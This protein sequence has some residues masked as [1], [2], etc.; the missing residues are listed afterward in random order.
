MQKPLKDFAQSLK[1]V[2]Q[3][4]PANYPISPIFKSIADEETIRS[5]VLAFKDF[6]CQFFDYVIAVASLHD[7][8]KL[9]ANRVWGG[10]NFTMDYPFLRDMAMTL[11]N[12]G[13]HGEPNNNNDALIIN[14]SEL[15]SVSKKTR[16]SKVTVYLR[17]LSEC[18]IEIFGIDLDTEKPNLTYTNILEITYPD[19]PVMLIGLKAMA[20]AQLE[21]NKKRF[22]PGAA[23]CITLMDTIFL[24]CDH[25]ALCGEVAE[26]ISLIKDIS[27]PFPVG[28]RELVLSLH[29]RLIDAGFICDTFTGRNSSIGTYFL[30]NYKRKPKSVS[31]ASWIIGITPNSCG[32][33]IDAKNASEY[34]EVIEKFPQ[35]L[36][37]VIK[38]GS[39]CIHTPTIHPLNNTGYKFIIDGAEYLKCSVFVCSNNNF[40]VPLTDL[41]NEKTYAIKGWV[42]KELS[43]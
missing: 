8:P 31:H 11:M 25:K 26:H 33:K 43:Y 14:G 40:W 24:R 13:L 27:K 32:I 9:N 29:L 18:G 42:E 28:T 2:L 10:I 12:I 1:D 41:T 3:D 30:Y 34:P 22:K 4:I 37:K 16:V 5:G 21:A 38:I 36:L 15:L 17:H 39:G 35:D 6:L 7:K 20:N 19:N 23:A